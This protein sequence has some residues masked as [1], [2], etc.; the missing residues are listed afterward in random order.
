MGEKYPPGSRHAGDQD[1]A[2]ARV[3]DVE[4]LALRA[5]IREVGDEVAAAGLHAIE[6]LAAMVEDL[7]RAHVG[8]RHGENLGLVDRHAVGP[9]GASKGD[10]EDYAWPMAM[11]GDRHTAAY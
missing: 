8:V 2:H 6:R 3:G 5:A 4:R 10:L 1:Q 9:A 7:H 11:V